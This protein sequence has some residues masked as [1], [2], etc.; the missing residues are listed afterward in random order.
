MIETPQP[1]RLRYVR[2]STYEQTLDAQLDQLCADDCIRIY[3]ETAS[4]KLAKAGGR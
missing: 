2:V 1:R 4:G 3:R